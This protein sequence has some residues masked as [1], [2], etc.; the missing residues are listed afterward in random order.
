MSANMTAHGMPWTAPSPEIPQPTPDA[1]RTRS[2]LLTALSSLRRTPWFESAFLRA[3]RAFQAVGLTV[4]PNHFYWPIPDL[5]RLEQRDWSPRTPGLDLRLDDQ[6]EFASTIS[7]RYSLELQFPEEGGEDDSLYHR[8][9]GFFETVDADIA[10]SMVRSKKPRRIIE[11][12]GGFSTRLMAQAARFNTAEGNPCELISVEPYPDQTL[13][14]G[15]DGLSLLI[16]RRVQEVPLE[17]FDSLQAGDI[18]FIDSSHVVSVGSD[19]VYEFFEILPRL[20]KGVIVHMHD[21]FYPSDYPRDAVLRFLWFW[22]E[23]YLLEA[24]LTANSGFQILWGSSAMLMLCPEVL[25]SSFPGWSR[26]YTKMPA[27]AR[28]FI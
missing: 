1:S 19:V 7:S 8:N 22:S 15:F 2:P 10:Y 12:G 4:L 18:L 21:I 25:E 17:L 26:S 28:Q 3:F 6:A 16:P 27:K 9:N 24:F 20:R 14:R 23:Q 13:R 5:R 11:I